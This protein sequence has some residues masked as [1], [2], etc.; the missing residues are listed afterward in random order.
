MHSSIQVRTHHFTEDKWDYVSSMV[1]VGRAPVWLLR[2]LR[3]RLAAL[4]SSA[5]PERGLP[6]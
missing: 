1:K 2:F 5:L 6:S 4:G 3:A